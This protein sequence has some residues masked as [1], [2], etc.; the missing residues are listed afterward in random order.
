[1]DAY[2][3]TG[4]RGFTFDAVAKASGV[5][6]PAIYRRWDSREELLVAAFDSVDFPIATDEG[7]LRADLEAYAGAWVRWFSTPCLPEAGVLIL[8]DSKAQPELGAL[9]QQRILEPR[10]HAVRSV[11]TRAV[12]R[13]ELPESTSV[14]AVPELLLGAF[15]M[16]WSFAAAHDDA[17][18]DGL[19]EFA[20][21]T[22][23]AVVRGLQVPGGV[24]AG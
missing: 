10:V 12:E 22:V 2:A 21:R 1:M 18:R 16:H 7:S 17:F 5:G 23:E 6:K 11:T 4:W 20:R 9:Y 14:T 8:A 15:F 13:G 19:G 3:A 24:A